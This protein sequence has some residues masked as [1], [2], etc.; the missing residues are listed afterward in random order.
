[1]LADPKYPLLSILLINFVASDS[2]N[3]R[4][5]LPAATSALWIALDI[6]DCSKLTIVPFLFLICNIDVFF[7]L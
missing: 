7:E 1:L 6:F 4:S 3:Y 5:D 2:A